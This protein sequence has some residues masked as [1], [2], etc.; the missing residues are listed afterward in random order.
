MNSGIVLNYSRQSL[1]VKQ[2]CAL[3]NGGEPEKISGCKAESFIVRFC[4]PAKIKPLTA[5]TNMMKFVRF[6]DPFPRFAFKICPRSLFPILDFTN[7]KNRAVNQC[8]FLMRR[9]AAVL[10]IGTYYAKIITSFG[11]S[12][13][14]RR[15]P[16]KLRYYICHVR[17][18]FFIISVTCKFLNAKQMMR[19]QIHFAPI[20]LIVIRPWQCR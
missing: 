2:R 13:L 4:S 3:W 8:H 9:T 19:S 15:V 1:F 6:K 12:D 11:D 14:R 5:G 18:E 16:G 17:G 7:A 20:L 10:I